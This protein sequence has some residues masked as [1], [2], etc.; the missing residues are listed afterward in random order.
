MSVRK[1][2]QNKFPYF[3]TANIRGKEPFFDNIKFA[4]IAAELLVRAEAKYKIDLYAFVIMPHHI[5]VLFKT[6]EYTNLSR[7]MQRYK[8][9]VYQQWRKE[10]GFVNKVWQKSFDYR[11]KN[12]LESFRKSLDYMNNNPKKLLLP[13]KYYEIPYMYFNDLKIE[14]IS[15]IFY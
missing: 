6:S 4:E 1:I 8:S 13:K 7:V 5:H 15:K 11:I 3:V 12:N 14:R 2:Y 9:Y 10:L